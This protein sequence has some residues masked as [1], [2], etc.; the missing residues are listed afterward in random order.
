MMVTA[1][2]VAAVIVGV[3]F[4]LDQ[5]RGTSPVPVGQVSV[6]EPAPE[7][8][9]A[10]TTGNISTES[11]PTAEVID[12]PVTVAS[13]VPEAMATAEPQAELPDQLIDVEGD[14]SLDAAMAVLFNIWRTPIPAADA[15]PCEVAASF[16]LRCL[17][18]LGSLRDI[19]H[20]DRPVAVKLE[21][22]SLEHYVVITGIEDG[23]V[24]V[25]STKGDYRLAE[26]DVIRTW[27]GNFAAL[28]KMPPEYRAVKLGDDGATVD[29]LYRQLS[30]VQGTGA[31]TAIV[32]ESFDENLER[33]VKQFQISQGLKP[34]GIAG[35]ITWIHLNS[36]VGED[37]PRL[38]SSD[39]GS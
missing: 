35:A 22:A 19:H 38:A 23:I 12:E 24:D 33:R 17:F 13:V 4:Y 21:I 5:Y 32:G 25:S 27:D 1:A 7:A 16:G 20:L 6:D 2:M 8:L 31:E 34:D 18:Q 26:R 10:D 37:L 9:P 36:A 29:W 30:L 3:I 14:A 28:W 15:V 11:E 39:G